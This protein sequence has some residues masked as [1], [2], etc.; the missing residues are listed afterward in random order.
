M[1]NDSLILSSLPKTWI[2]DVD[3]TIVKHNGHLQGQDILL[4]G[5]SEFLSTLSPED[6]VILL[7]AREKKYS[8]SLINFLK[9]KKIKYDQIIF[10]MPK[11]ERILINDSKPSGLET[12]FAINIKRDSGLDIRYKIDESL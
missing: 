9:E 8:E 11:G 3:G 1:K 7:T 10:D 4:P 2:L 6:K 12:A 5:V